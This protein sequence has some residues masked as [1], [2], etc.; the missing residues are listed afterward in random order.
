VDDRAILVGKA[1]STLVLAFVTLAV[2]WL[3]TTF[4]FGARWGDPLAVAAVLAAAVAAVAGVGSL[5][6]GVARTEQ[7]AMAWT[8]AISFTL[9][10]LGGGFQQPGSLPG[11][12]SRLTLL[13][14]N[15]WTLAALTRVGAADA[16][17]VDVLPTVAVLLGMAAVTMT[18]GVRLLARRVRA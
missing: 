16:G 10:L 18:V 4:A 8:A 12:L 11:F 5:V 6:T 14:P 17:L 15:G 1:L 9:T 7:Q 2:M 3:V 13:T